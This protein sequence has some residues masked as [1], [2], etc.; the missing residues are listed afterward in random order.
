MHHHV[1]YSIV[2]ITTHAYVNEMFAERTNKRELRQLSPRL[3][4]V[5]GYFSHQKIPKQKPQQLY[6]DQISPYD[7]SHRPMQLSLHPAAV[8]A[9]GPSRRPPY[10]I[11]PPL[12]Q[13]STSNRAISINLSPF[14]VI[15]T[16]IVIIII[17]IIIITT[18][19][20]F[21]TT[22]TTTTGARPESRSPRYKVQLLLAE[23]QRRMTREKEDETETD[24]PSRNHHFSGEDLLL[25]GYRLSYHV[26]PFY[27]RIRDP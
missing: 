20:I 9:P 11:T 19:S 6:K 17:I 15:I 8:K 24:E 27:V 2:Y 26:F 18:L 16:I 7:W 1:I 3:T 10:Q 4:F 21:Y 22:T 23:W 14:V 12:S 13:F 5:Y 25:Y